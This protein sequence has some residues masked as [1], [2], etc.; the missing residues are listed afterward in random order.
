VPGQISS[1]VLE[2][3][4]QLRDGVERR[5][6]RDVVAEKIASLISSGILQVGDVLPSE[7]DLATA[8]QVSRETVRGGMQILAARGIIE[9]SH[10]A[11]T[12]VISADVGPLAA[13][14]RAPKLI[15]SYDIEAIHAARMLVE[16]SVVAAAALRIDGATLRLLDDALIAQRAATDDPVRFLISDRE[17][18]LA[19]Y[20]A[21]G[22]PVLADFVGDLYAYMMEHRRE[23][24]SRPG[25]ILKS[26]RDHE[27]IVAALR[28]RDPKGVVSAF[29]RHIKR[30]YTTT[31]AVMGASLEDSER[32]GPK[33]SAVGS[34][35]PA[36]KSGTASP[37]RSAFDAKGGG[38]STAGKTQR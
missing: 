22:N 31:I 25:A 17:F 38:T 15:N 9:V 10:G 2:H 21:C 11:R 13:G 24:V 4:T 36:R 12:R 33:L 6:V 20:R 16:T 23:A 29:E 3:V 5:H 35:S 37:A 32:V 34:Q 19:I 14:L 8:I 27:V 18:H 30:I 28:A 26:L 1:L 7:R